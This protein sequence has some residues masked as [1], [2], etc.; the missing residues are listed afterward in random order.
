MGCADSGACFLGAD[1]G[2]FL[3]VQTVG[4]ALGVDSGDCSL[5]AD[6]GGFL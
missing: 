3:E 1:S 6:S 5:G 2:G 4:A